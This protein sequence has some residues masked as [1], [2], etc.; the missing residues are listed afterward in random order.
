MKKNLFSLIKFAFGWPLSIL[1]IGYLGY[2]VFKNAPIILSKITSVHPLLMIVGIVSFL[3][4]FFLRAYSWQLILKAYGFKTEFRQANYLWGK[5]EARRYIPGNVWSFLSRAYL[6]SEIGVPKKETSKG[7]VLEAELIVLGSCLVSLLSLAFVTYDVL[8]LEGMFAQLVIYGVWGLMLIG[9]IVYIFQKAL[10][11][12]IGLSNQKIL[13]FVFPSFPAQTMAMLVGLSTLSFFFFGLGYYL[14][15]GS[16]IFLTPE[17]I[18]ELLGFFALSYILGYLSLITPSGLGVREGAIS[19]G[20]LSLVS[21]EI[22]NF[23][24]LITRFVLT[25]TEGIYLGISYILTLKNKRIDQLS[26]F[27]TKRSVESILAVGIVLF[28]LYFSFVSI[29]RYDNFYTGRFDLGNMAQTVWNT[30]Q[31]SIF[32]LT[33]PNGVENASRLGTHADF[34]LVLFAPFYFLWE[35]PRMLLILQALVVGLGAIFVYKLALHILKSR[36]FALT[37]GLLYLLNPSVQRSTIYDFHAVVL[38]T[39]FLLGAY[40]FILKKRYVWFLFFAFLAGITK[41]QIWLIVALFGGYIAVIQKKWLWGGLLFIFGFILTFYFV[42]YA[43][44]NNSTGT[45]FALSYY[46]DYGE[47]PSDVAVNIFLQPVKTISTILLPERI[48][49]LKQLFLPVGY[50]SLFFPFILIFAG[51]DLL[52]GLLSNNPQLHQIYYQYT[53]SITPFIFISAMYGIFYLV[54][55]IPRIPQ[56]VH[57]SLLI[58]LGVYGVYLYGPLPGSQSPNLDMFLRSMPNRE[59]VTDIIHRIPEQ[60]SVAATNNAG[61]HLSHR[62]ELFTLPNGIGKADVIVILSDPK[63]D[64]L[65]PEQQDLIDNLST[66]S[67]YMNE[68]ITPQ[69][70]VFKKSL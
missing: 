61:S 27:L 33:D 52:I 14:V 19:F 35:D 66:S 51:P 22:G 38:A 55:V 47:K 32:Q 11:T 18:L 53:A 31:G 59:Q 45:H 28:V 67:A 12:R 5:S 29:A 9:L 69:I 46:S 70:V 23:I 16:I 58:A 13:Q 8:H 25:I 15:A 36:S 1:A 65:S 64:T 3:V 41:E 30:K 44:P 56:I 43:I 50:Y 7:L 10:L 68:V 62:K 24:A 4:Y 6:F 2:S 21:L 54:K 34:I 39:T 49:Y 37:F 40:Y 17:K 26:D 57:L 60:Y 63:A 42:S 48:E 20:L